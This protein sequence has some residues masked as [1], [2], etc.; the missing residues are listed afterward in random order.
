MTEASSDTTGQALLWGDREDLLAVLALRFGSV[1]EPVHTRIVACN[2]P[3]TLERWILVAAN[4]PTWAAFLSDFDTG[5][6]AFKLI[7]AAYQPIPSAAD[8]EPHAKEE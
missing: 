5:P 4:V 3:A 2:D 8:D 1:P 6:N 7:G